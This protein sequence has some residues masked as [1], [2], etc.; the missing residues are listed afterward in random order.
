M[1]YNPNAITQ[2]LRNIKTVGIFSFNRIAGSQNCFEGLIEQIK[3][4]PNIGKF[5]KVSS[6]LQT[7]GVSRATLHSSK[8][9]LN[10]MPAMGGNGKFIIEQTARFMRRGSKADEAFKTSEEL[11]DNHLKK[12]NFSLSSQS[13]KR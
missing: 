10:T 4:S 12:H 9:P 13:L 11:L 2:Y 8:Y 5:L 3:E 7:M 6:V 1:T